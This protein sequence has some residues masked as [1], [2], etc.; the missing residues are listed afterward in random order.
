MKYAALDVLALVECQWFLL[1]TVALGNTA[2][3]ALTTFVH[4]SLDFWT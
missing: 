1:C 4:A 2:K 3:W